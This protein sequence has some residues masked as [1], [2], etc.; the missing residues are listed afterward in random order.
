MKSTI[1]ITIFALISSII[2]G[3]VAVS[4]LKLDYQKENIQKFNKKENTGTSNNY[5]ILKNH[6]GYIGVFNLYE[7]EPIMVLDTHI[8]LLPEYDQ[9]QLEIGVIA[10]NYDILTKLIEDYIS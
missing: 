5:Y 7:L 10:E 9:K 3:F 2:L 6:N 4:S 8:S 1:S